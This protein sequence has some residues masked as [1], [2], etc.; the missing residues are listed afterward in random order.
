MEMMENAQKEQRKGVALQMHLD[1]L[2]HQREVK[3][4]AVSPLTIRNNERSASAWPSRTGGS[5]T[6]K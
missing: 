2:S 3:R 6:I 5:A 1:N 4:I